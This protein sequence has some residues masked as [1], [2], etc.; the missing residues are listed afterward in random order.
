VGFKK[1]EFLS[2]GF[3]DFEALSTLI[4][5]NFFYSGCQ[6]FNLPFDCNALSKSSMNLS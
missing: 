4:F 6:S 1:I 2:G 5:F 3:I